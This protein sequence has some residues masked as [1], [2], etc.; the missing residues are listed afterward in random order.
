MVCGPRLGKYGPDGKPRPIPGH[1][2]TIVMLGTF[3]LAFG[4]FGF[5]PGSTLAGTDNRI[6]VIAGDTML[7]GGSPLPSVRWSPSIS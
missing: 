5:N 2:T 1:D 6:A 3:I 7:A 4:W